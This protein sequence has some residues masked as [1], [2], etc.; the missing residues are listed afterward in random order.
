MIASVQLCVSVA[1]RITPSLARNPPVNGV[2]AW[3]TRN[4]ANASASAG[5][6][7]ERPL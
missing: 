2:P 6:L 3:A 4:T 5:R 7:R 1:A